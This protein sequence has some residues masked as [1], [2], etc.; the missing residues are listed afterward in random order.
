[1]PRPYRTLE[2][3][4]VGGRTTRPDYNPNKRGLVDEP[5]GYWGAHHGDPTGNQG[6]SDSSGNEGNNQG[7]PNRGITSMRD[8]GM[9]QGSSGYGPAGAGGM[10]QGPSGN[11][12]NM[13]GFLTAFTT[14]ETKQEWSDFLS[15]PDI[16]QEDKDTTIAEAQSTNVEGLSWGGPH[17]SRSAIRDYTTLQNLPDAIKNQIQIGLD[18]VNKEVYNAFFAKKDATTAQK[19]ALARALRY[20]NVAAM[21]SAIGPMTTNA[22]AA[23][24]AGLTSLQSHVEA[25]SSLGEQALNAVT[26]A[27]DATFADLSAQYGKLGLTGLAADNVMGLVDTYGFDPVAK[28]IG[29]LGV[30]ATMA[31]QMFGIVTGKPAMAASVKSWTKNGETLAQA[32]EEGTVTKDQV[33]KS[34]EEGDMMGSMGFGIANSALGQALGM[35]SYAGGY[36]DAEK[37]AALGYSYS[38][39]THGMTDAQFGMVSGSLADPYGQT[40]SQMMG[41]N[42]APDHGGGRPEPVVNTT[43]QGSSTDEGTGEWTQGQEVQVDTSNF[44][45]SQM[46]IFNQMKS[47]GY[48]D[49]YAYQYAGMII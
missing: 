5:G 10:A 41:S 47:Y 19:H 28:A 12:G 30:E 3:V 38:G 35:N 36:V 25:F 15:N 42:A 23:Y 43:Q 31:N 46:Q 17:A 24:H 34:N 4:M 48:S 40:M 14:P 32:L 22:L 37:A 26:P 27:Q 2:D 18:D 29:A 8:S 1:M 44:D 6:D 13:Q 9:V 33:M 11:Q 21:E 49:E 7:N 16:S 39:S 20:G 45:A